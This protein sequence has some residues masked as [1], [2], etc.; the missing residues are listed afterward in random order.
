MET[1]LQGVQTRAESPF[2]YWKIPALSRLLDG[3]DD[4]V[5]RLQQKMISL[6]DDQPKLAKA[7]FLDKLTSTDEGTLTRKQLIGNLITF[8]IAGSDTSS[9]S[10]SWLLYHFAVQPELQAAVAAEVASLPSGT[11]AAH[12]VKSLPLLQ[13]S[14]LE[15]LRLNAVVPYIDLKNTQPITLHGRKLPAHS[16]ILV[17][18]RHMWHSL[19][20]FSGSDLQAFRPG[21]FLDSEGRLK[22]A[23]A[24]LDSI[25]FGH[26]ARRCPGMGLANTVGPW[27][28][29]EV[30]RLYQIEPWH[31]APLAEKSGFVQEPAEHVRLSLL[32]R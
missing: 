22:P 7:Q 6:L 16:D 17:L 20:E 14:W 32:R 13:A 29:A 11:A 26:G 12:H 3:A 19:P 1:F 31:G 24:P 9:I 28:V 4:A 18:T 8:F 27:M 21:R 30:L 25:A 10:M 23:A 5:E 15:V 2:P